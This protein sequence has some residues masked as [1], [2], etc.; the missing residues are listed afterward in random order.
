MK[1]SFF[2]R[3]KIIIKTYEHIIM[4]RNVSWILFHLV[5]GCCSS[6]RFLVEFKLEVVVAEGGL[7]SEGV[8]L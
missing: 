4:A 2:R 8:L 1:I 6:K 7:I 5:L 3:K